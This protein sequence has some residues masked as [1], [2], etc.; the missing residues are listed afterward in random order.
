MAVGPE[1]MHSTLNGSPLGLLRLQGVF[2]P[3]WPHSRSTAEHSLPVQ[4]RPPGP[5]LRGGGAWGPTKAP[6]P[7]AC[8]TTMHPSSKMSQLCDITA[9]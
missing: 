3:G 2:T 9:R 5:G 8:R 1:K 7:K 6:P 4:T